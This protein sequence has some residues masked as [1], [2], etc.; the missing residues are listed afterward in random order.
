MG[1]TEQRDSD[2]AGR[3]QSDCASILLGTNGR[4]DERYAL[5]ENETYSEGAGNSVRT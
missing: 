2:N 5:I 3:R 4:R 1:T